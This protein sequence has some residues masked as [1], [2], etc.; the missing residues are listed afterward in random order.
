MAKNEIRKRKVYFYYKRQKK[1][2]RL[3]QK[4]LDKLKADFEEKL[5]LQDEDFIKKVEEI[6]A[7]KK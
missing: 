3:I 7:S 2:D 6:K 1:I 4:E 5:Q